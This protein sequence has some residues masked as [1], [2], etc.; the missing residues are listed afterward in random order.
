MDNIPELAAM[1]RR[2]RWAVLGKCHLMSFADWRTWAGLLIAVG[3]ALSGQIAVRYLF[4]PLTARSAPLMGF[5]GAVV[6][7]LV[8]SHVSWKIRVHVVR[9][10]VRKQFPYSCQ[11]CGYDLR[12]SQGRCPECGTNAEQW[13]APATMPE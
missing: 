13:N 6:F 4:P 9:K 11:T 5:S 8:G 12:A 10:L 7:W 1:T 3:L 2:E